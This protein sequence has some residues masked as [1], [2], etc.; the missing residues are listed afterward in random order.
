MT[1]KK[2]KEEFNLF[3]ENK[4]FFKNLESLSRTNYKERYGYEK[5]NYK[6]R[7]VVKFSNSNNG[8]TYKNL[9]FRYTKAAIKLSGFDISCSR[10]LNNIS[11]FASEK[12]LSLWFLPVLKD[13]FNEAKNQSWYN[14]KS[15]DMFVNN[16]IH[17]DVSSYTQKEINLHNNLVFLKDELNWSNEKLFDF[18]KTSLLLSQA[19]QSVV[20]NLTEVY[21]Y[22]NDVSMEEFKK[23]IR[24]HIF[25]LG[26]VINKE[27]DVFKEKN[28]EGINSYCVPQLKLNS[29]LRKAAREGDLSQESKELF[30]DLQIPEFDLKVLEAD[31]NNYKYFIITAEQL[32]ALSIEKTLIIDNSIQNKPSGLSFVK[33]QRK[34]LNGLNLAITEMFANNSEDLLTRNR[35]QGFIDFFNKAPGNIEDSVQR[36]SA[37]N[38]LFDN[39]YKKQFDKDED[40][41]MIRFSDKVSYKEITEIMETITDGLIKICN[42]KKILDSLSNEVSKRNKNVAIFKNVFEYVKA[43]KLMKRLNDIEISSLDNDTNI[44]ADADPADYKF[45]GFKI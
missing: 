8:N 17:D 33:N 7:D 45:G 13:F 28:K 22:L 9:E 3:L 18:L 6:I 26:D 14:E 4:G 10:D 38:N 24:N 2:F 43:E 12:V 15:R 37:I 36:A 19:E 31:M 30:K 11:S 5:D 39:K 27:I 42:D 25:E 35:F 23:Y 20:N 40:F 21:L 32:T 34:I 41:L 16:M 29:V 44:D 1:L